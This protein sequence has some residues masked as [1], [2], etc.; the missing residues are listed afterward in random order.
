MPEHRISDKSGGRKTFAQLFPQLFLFPLVMVA[1]GVMVW[2]FFHASAEDNRSV[3][4]LIGDI[5]SG[6][7][8]ARKQDMYALAIKTREL[9]AEEGRSRYF[10]E[11]VTRKLLR[12]L[13]RSGD[14]DVAF[15][16]Y[17]TAAVGRAGVPGLTLPIMSG[18]AA[19]EGRSLD[20]RVH[21]VQALG[22]CG[23]KDAIPVL[24]KILDASHEPEDWDLR[25]V[26]LASLAN[27]GDPA[28]VP[29][30]RRSVEDRRLDVSWSAACWLANFFEDSQGIALLRKLTDWAF[31]DAAR[32]DRDRALSSSE[33]EQYMVMAIEGLWRLEKQE[34]L[35]VLHE[36][37][38][39]SRSMKVRNAALQLLARAKAPDRERETESPLLKG[40]RALESPKGQ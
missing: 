38:K 30:L 21:A 27:L 40:P 13:E 24:E 34:S 18:I 8:H 32:G 15:R 16:Q 11:D 26:A 6:G 39:D 12:L 3:E 28:A 14:E 1:V 19:D 17:L 2:L 10:S 37:S 9:T 23:S 25:W 7:V 5:E 33:K 31:L 35:D 20:E 4:E 29:Y 36:K 22:L